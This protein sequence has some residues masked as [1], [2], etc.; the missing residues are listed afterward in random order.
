[1]TRSFS[2]KLTTTGSGTLVLLRPDGEST[3]TAPI[4][5][6]VVKDSWLLTSSD[7]EEA[8]YEGWYEK[9]GIPTIWDMPYTLAPAVTA[10]ASQLSASA[11]ASS[12]A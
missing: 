9:E 3:K 11:S 10:S 8:W 6:I 7:L 2:L 12:S 5:K 1:M 4:D